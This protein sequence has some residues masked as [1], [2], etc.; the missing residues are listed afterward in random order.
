MLTAGALIKSTEAAKRKERGREKEG[1]RMEVGG[2][3][4]SSLRRLPSMSSA[5]DWR[6]KQFAFGDPNNLGGKLRGA[7]EE[8]DRHCAPLEFETF[9]YFNY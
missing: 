8:R 5:G 3:S 1:S 7:G 6:L 9:F 2:E 4:K